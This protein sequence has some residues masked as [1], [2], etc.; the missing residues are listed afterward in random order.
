MIGASKVMMK[1][2]IEKLELPALAVTTC[3]SGK[4]GRIP[5]SKLWV[6]SAA[7]AGWPGTAAANMLIQAW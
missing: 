3:L 5:T 4:L 1:A 7:L 2:S 6:K